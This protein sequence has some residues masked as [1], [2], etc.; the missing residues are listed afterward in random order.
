MCTTWGL[1]DMV[2]K[3]QDGIFPYLVDE[4]KYPLLS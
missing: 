2:V 3:S 4:K 1:F